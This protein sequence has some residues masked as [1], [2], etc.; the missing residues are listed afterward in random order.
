M[1]GNFGIKTGDVETV[2][3]VN[4]AGVG[5]SI[6]C[7]HFWRPAKPAVLNSP[8]HPWW[9]FVGDIMFDKPHPAVPMTAYKLHSEDFYSSVS[10]RMF[11]NA[12][13]MSFLANQIYGTLVTPFSDLNR[14][15]KIFINF[16]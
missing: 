3:T 7:F 2:D 15:C 11:S 9:W 4:A 16:L 14:Y 12:D 5:N 6:Y 8:L 10:P 1:C 13:C